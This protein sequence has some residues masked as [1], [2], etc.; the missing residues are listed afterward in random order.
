MNSPELLPLFQR[1]SGALAKQ[2]TPSLHC[3]RNDKR[4]TH[5]TGLVCREYWT[6]IE[7]RKNDKKLLYASKEHLPEVMN[8]SFRFL[9]MFS[10]RSA[11]TICTPRRE[12]YC[13]F[14][15]QLQGPLTVWQHL[16]ES[17]QLGSLPEGTRDRRANVLSWQVQTNRHVYWT[18]PAD[19]ASSPITTAEE[20]WCTASNWSLVMLKTAAVCV[21]FDS[22]PDWRCIT[23][24]WLSLAHRV[25]L[26]TRVGK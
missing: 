19:G 12:I 10:L 18:T 17:M 3:S 14:I 7:H 13:N 6:Q 16:K 15:N 2:T 11:S 21:R 1:F 22:E 8:A 26:E 20:C 25:M 23:H 24:R 5:K 9:I 4:W